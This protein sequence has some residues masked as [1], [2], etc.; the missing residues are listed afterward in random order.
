MGVLGVVKAS[1]EVDLAD[2]V[3]LNLQPTSQDW[4]AHYTWPTDPHTLQAS[5]QLRLT[6]TEEVGALILPML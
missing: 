5:S 1:L 6:T 2:T 3:A 4:P